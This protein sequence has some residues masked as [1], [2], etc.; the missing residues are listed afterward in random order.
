LELGDRDRTLL[1]QSN[2]REKP[3]EVRPVVSRE[4]IVQEHRTVAKY[5]DK[6]LPS[7]IPTGDLLRRVPRG[8]VERSRQ[9]WSAVCNVLA[10]RFPDVPNENDPIPEILR[11]FLIAVNLSTP[12][13]D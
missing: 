4:Y 9:V 12:Q 10:M 8:T 2:S 3:T 5:I 7:L 1:E 6:E 11:V 13:T